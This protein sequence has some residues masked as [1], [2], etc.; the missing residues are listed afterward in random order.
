[1]MAP[2]PLPNR[3]TSQR[4]WLASIIPMIMSCFRFSTMWRC[5]RISTLTSYSAMARIYSIFY[6]KYSS[7][8]HRKGIDDVTTLTD[9]AAAWGADRSAGKCGTTAARRLATRRMAGPGWPGDDDGALR[10]LA[11]YPAAGPLLLHCYG[12]LDQLYE[13]DAPLAG[14]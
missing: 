6:N 4:H 11:W 12:A 3:S 14:E 7:W 9:L 5:A 1:M 2:F 10:R 8:E 13:R